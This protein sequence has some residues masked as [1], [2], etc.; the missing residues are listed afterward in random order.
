MQ[1]RERLSAVRFLGL[2]IGV[3]N[4]THFN[5]VCASP[6]TSSIL[7]SICDQT[8][9]S[10]SRVLYHS[11]TPWRAIIRC[12][13]VRQVTKLR[14]RGMQFLSVPDKYYDNLR[15]R[16]KKSPI[17]VAEDLDQVWHSLTLDQVWHSP[18]INYYYYFIFSFF[19]SAFLPE[20]HNLRNIIIQAN[21]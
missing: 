20:G 15:E 10:G 4:N 18:I 1:T 2:L 17:T 13:L 7:C 5:T 3:K 19:Q 14:E 6:M 16:L 12:V 9:L 8:R 21:T 11:F